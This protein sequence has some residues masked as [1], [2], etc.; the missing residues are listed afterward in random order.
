MFQ[1]DYEIPE[2]IIFYVFSENLQVI[3]MGA[4]RMQIVFAISKNIII[5]I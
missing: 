4:F 2:I 3:L 5:L 1:T